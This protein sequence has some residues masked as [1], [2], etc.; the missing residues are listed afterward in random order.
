MYSMSKER[1]FYS[2]AKSSGQCGFIEQEQNRTGV[3]N[4]VCRMVNK[5]GAPEL[6]RITFARRGWIE[7]R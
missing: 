1:S 4:M 3:N 6:E 5:E 2:L 7:S